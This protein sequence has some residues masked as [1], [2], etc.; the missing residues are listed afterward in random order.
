VYEYRVRV[1]C[2]ST[3]YEYST[4]WAALPAYEYSI[5]TV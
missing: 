1:Q 5:S 4:V 2:M 3:E